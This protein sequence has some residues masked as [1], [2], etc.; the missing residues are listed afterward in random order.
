MWRS[1]PPKPPKVTVSID[2]YYP[3]DASWSWAPVSHYGYAWAPWIPSSV[4]VSPGIT[5]LARVWVMSEFK[6]HVRIPP[7]YS[8]LRSTIGR[9]STIA[10]WHSPLAIQGG[11]SENRRRHG[12]SP[13]GVE[14]P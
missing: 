1:E 13:E 7:Y 10:S 6:V 3:A 12:G 2:R 11:T 8:P 5:L 14:D 9:I 4:I